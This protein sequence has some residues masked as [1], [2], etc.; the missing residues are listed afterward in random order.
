MT[1][2]RAAGSKAADPA[3]AEVADQNPGAKRSEVQRRPRN[4]PRRVERAAR[5]KASDQIA[6]SVENV[7]E[8]VSRPLHIVVLQFVLLCVRHEQIA[9]NERNAERRITGRHCWVGKRSCKLYRQ[10]AG[11]KH[12]DGTCSEIGRVQKNAR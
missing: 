8:P 2:E 4:P 5:R 1:A 6:I 11:V 10:E 9:I 12:I 7:D 3:I